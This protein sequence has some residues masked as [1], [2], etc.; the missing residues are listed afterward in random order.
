MLILF[1]CNLCGNEIKKYFKKKEESVLKTGDPIPPYLICSCGGILEKQL[2]DFE[3][4]S[5][6]N[7]DNGAM[8]RKV[9]LRRDAKV[10]HREKGDKYIETIKNRETI[11]K[12]NED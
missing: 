4:S 3:T 9:E 2:P 5:F 12:K 6:E 11:I 8:A 7:V 10:K 1:K